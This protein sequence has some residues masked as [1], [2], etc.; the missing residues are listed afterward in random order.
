MVISW[1]TRNSANTE[2]PT[3]RD[4]T[5]LVLPLS[6]TD[7]MEQVREAVGSL[8]GWRVEPTGDPARLHLTRR[9][10]LWGFVDDVK[11]RFLPAGPGCM[12]HA[13]SCS[14]IGVGDLGQNRRNILE[15]WDTVRQQISPGTGGR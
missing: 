3:H 4:L 6:P 2:T 15:L 5:P 8:P 12:I 1:F 14:R 10:R 9:T 13:E 11:L 7:A